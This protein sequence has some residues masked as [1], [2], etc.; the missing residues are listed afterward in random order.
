MRM[1]VS[2]PDDLRRCVGS[3]A[4]EEGGGGDPGVGW[5]GSIRTD[6][7]VPLVL[8]FLPGLGVNLG[9]PCRHWW[10]DVR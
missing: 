1:A 3:T 8:P 5:L 10:L 6:F 9:W 7:E 4:Q 2:Y